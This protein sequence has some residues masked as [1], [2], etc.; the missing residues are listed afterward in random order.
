MMDDKNDPKQALNLLA[1]AYLR[2]IQ[3]ISKQE[4]QKLRDLID[5]AKS[6]ENNIHLKIGEVEKTLQNDQKEIYNL[7]GKISSVNKK[8]QEVQDAY[9]KEIDQHVEKII[10]KLVNK[11]V[12]KMLKKG[13]TLKTAKKKEDYN[14][15]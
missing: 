3:S 2:D 13:I 5:N 15:F 11:M 8:F 4:Q 9:L 1:G 14:D 7:S 12:K 10:K 6:K